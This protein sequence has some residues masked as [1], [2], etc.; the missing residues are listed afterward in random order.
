MNSNS[1][2]FSCFVLYFSLVSS[3]IN[4]LIISALISWH[5]EASSHLTCRFLSTSFYNLVQL[6]MSNFFR[7]FFEKKI[8]MH[9]FWIVSS[10]FSKF[11]KFMLK[12]WMQIFN[13]C[14]STSTRKIS[15]SLI[16]WINKRIMLIFKK[17]KTRISLNYTISFKFISINSKVS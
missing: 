5:Y 15:K 12:Q 9:H 14:W 8:S 16:C 11:M 3:I 6:T 13:E 7:F 17:Q 10:Q 1:L 2:K 4:T